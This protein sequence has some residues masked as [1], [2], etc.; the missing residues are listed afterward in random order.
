LD[1]AFFFPRSNSVSA[2]TLEAIRDVVREELARPSSPWMDSG[3][4]AGYLGTTA[5]TLKNW[6]ATGK[7]PKYHVVQDRL[8]RY[9]RDDL[10]GFVRA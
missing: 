3:A 8:V 7:G 5:G 9:H 6:R 10:D 4:A 2:I 1:L